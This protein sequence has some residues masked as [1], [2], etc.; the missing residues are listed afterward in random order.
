MTS[1]SIET[2]RNYLRHL[3][4]GNTEGLISVFEDD[5]VVHSPFL[6]TMKAPDFFRKLAQASSASVITLID[7]FDSV[8]PTSEGGRVAAYFRYDWTLSD[9][10]VVDFTCVDVFEFRHGSA[11]IQAMH[12][13]YDTHPMRARVGDKYAPD[14]D[15]AA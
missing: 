4:A 15:R 9:G 13:V 12:I 3:H 11:R 1:T 8:H 5:G 14:P 2:V 7:L 10:R 6:G